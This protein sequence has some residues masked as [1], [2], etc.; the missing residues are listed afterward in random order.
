MLRKLIF[1][2]A[3]FML[4]GAGLSAQEAS[5][6]A[7][8]FVQGSR[9]RF[10][11]YVW[12][13]P[14]VDVYI[15]GQPVVE[16][17][18]FLRTTPYSEL[19]AGEHSIQFV[20]SGETLETSLLEPIMLE[21][22]PQEDYVIAL[23]GQLADESL[24]P[25]VANE[26]LAVA[27]FQDSAVPASYAILVHG[28]SDAP[29]IDFYMDDELLREAISFGKYAVIP[30]SVEPH[31][32]VVTFADDPESVLFENRGETPPSPDLLLLTVMVGT[33]P[34]GLD[35]TGAVSRLPQ[36]NILTQLAQYTVEKDGFAFTTL[37][38]AIEVAGLSETLSEEGE[39][40]LVAP[41]DEAFSKLA[42]EELEAL[43]NNPEALTELLTYH[44]IPQLFTTP[45]IQD[46]TELLTQQGMPVQVMLDGEEVYLNGIAKI[47]KGGFPVVV[48]GNI[49]VVDS[50]LALP[51]N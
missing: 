29:A 25:L 1:V 3:V 33:Y 48:N 20:P 31:D 47:L 34:D 6:E 8:A 49:L 43:L 7:S 50:V 40:T 19:S 32:I 27:E 35:V 28:I 12:D 17:L 10:A 38:Q 23:I 36:Q 9:L 13:A 16:A 51:E 21:L 5:P 2:F 42:P 24:Q 11:H 22:N 30:V 18:E 44:L 41:T 4:L 15:N 39:F 46:G 26:T 37:L 45:N 14:Q